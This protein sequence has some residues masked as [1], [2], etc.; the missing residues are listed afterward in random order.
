[1]GRLV[2]RPLAS[3]ILS[4]MTGFKWKLDLMPLRQ[5][6]LIHNNVRHSCGLFGIAGKES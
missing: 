2:N 4:S 3:G 6:G 5:R 1:M